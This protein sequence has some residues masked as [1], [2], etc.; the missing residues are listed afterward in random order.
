MPPTQGSEWERDTHCTTCKGKEQGTEREATEARMSREMQKEAAATLPAKASF[1]LLTSSRA[2]ATRAT[3]RDRS[4]PQAAQWERHEHTLTHESAA[5]L[6][7][8]CAFSRYFAACARL[9]YACSASS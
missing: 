2:G 8:S 9:T 7:C 3:L 4:R 6:I 5:Y 1:V